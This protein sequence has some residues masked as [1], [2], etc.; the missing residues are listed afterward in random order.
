MLHPW[1][2]SL[3]QE[4]SERL[5]QKQMHHGILL[6][7]EKGSGVSNLA[8][9]LVKRFLC[10]DSQTLACDA[11][12][13]CLLF[14]AQSHPDFHPV[15]TEKTQIGVDAVRAA[16]EQ[17]N[18]TAQLSANKVVL[19]ENI[20]TMSE[21]ASNALLKTLEEP[22]NNTYLV[23]T[24]HAPQYILATIKS[25]C[26]KIRVPMPNYQQ[27]LEYLKGKVETL[28]TE[29]MLAAYKQSPLLF[30]EQIHSD[31]LAFDEFEEDF[32]ALT[33]GQVNAEGIANK[34]KDQATDAV[35]WS[36][37]L[38]LRLFSA[39]VADT[40]DQ[41]HLVVGTHWMKVYD[42]ATHATKKLRQAGLN[43]VLILSAL[44]AL[45]QSSA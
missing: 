30:L 37:Q 6:V 40:T 25:R 34:W 8:Q 31:S 27:S 44:F 16:I 22:T 17:V 15:V 26:E 20:E 5:T 29:Q 24:T 14:K 2:D 13:A 33:K 36:A 28:P 3:M 42:N 21:S 4:L 32:T 19:I 39:E 11:C 10:S 12:K 1:L 41:N 9:M 35:N 7:G 23:L 18:K 38:S 45:I 43:K